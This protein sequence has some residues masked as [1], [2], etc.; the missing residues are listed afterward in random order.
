MKDDKP[1][2]ANFVKAANE[3]FQLGLVSPDD[4]GDPA[5]N[6]SPVFLDLWRRLADSCGSTCPRS[7][8]AL[9]FRLWNALPP[10]VLA[11]NSLDAREET[12]NV[13]S[14]LYLLEHNWVSAY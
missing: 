9:M 1:P 8:D 13:M 7:V 6:S 14:L 10:W 11:C 2:D 12:S 4:P 5:G 3:A